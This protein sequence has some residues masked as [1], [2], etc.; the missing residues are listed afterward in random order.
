MIRKRGRGSNAPIAVQEAPPARSATL[1]EAQFSDFEAVRDLR[2]R[3]GLSSDSPEN[4]DRLWRRNPALGR[5]VD[6]LPIGWVLESENRVVGYVGNIPLLYHYGGR[7][8]VTAAGTGL[9]VEP[10]YRA[11]TLILNAA[12]YRQKFVDLCLATTAI[13]VLGDIARLF[14]AVPLPQPDYDSVLFWVLRPYR[15]SEAVMRKLGL[16]H[17]SAIGCVLGSLALTSDRILRRRWPPRDSSTSEIREIGINEIGNDF[18]DLWR[19]KLKEPARLLADRSPATLRW[20]FDIPGDMGSTRVLCCYCNRQLRGYAVIRD[21]PPNQVNGLR[22]SIIVDILAAEDDPQIVES[23]WIAAYRHAKHAG[24][25]VFEVLGFPPRIR[26]ICEGWHPYIRKYPSCPF[27]YKVADPALQN[28]L[29]DTMVWYACPFD[30]DT[31]LW[32]FG[33]A[34]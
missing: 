24:S 2:H 31:T 19:Q 16:R 18:E 21:E 34:S 7:T 14:R 27:Y 9:V 1:R 11:S 13:G 15:F 22:R 28:A 4:W 20:H 33:T 3:F 30:G 29:A 10:G 5:I 6:R 32:S 25:H 23:L 17:F 8:L 26:R 12:F